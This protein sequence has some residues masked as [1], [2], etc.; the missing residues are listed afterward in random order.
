MLNRPYGAVFLFSED[1]DHRY[2]RRIENARDR[3]PAGKTRGDDHRAAGADFE[4]AAVVLREKAF[5]APDR[6]EA[7]GQAEHTVVGMAAGV[8]IRCASA[9]LQ[10]G[11]CFRL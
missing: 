3:A 8:E 11:G 5:G 1:I 9:D 2:L 6:A 7:E 4:F 10:G